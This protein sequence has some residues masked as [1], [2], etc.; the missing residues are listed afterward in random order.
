MS[1]KNNYPQSS[2]KVGYWTFKLYFVA[3]CKRVFFN[4]YVDSH[5]ERASSG[6]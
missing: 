5:L 1:N 4:V 3:G 6:H 2:Y